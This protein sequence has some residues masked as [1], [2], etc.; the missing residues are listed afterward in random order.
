[1]HYLFLPDKISALLADVQQH[2]LEL[3]KEMRADLDE[4]ETFE[5]S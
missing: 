1:M 2:L 5:E 4:E 3:Y